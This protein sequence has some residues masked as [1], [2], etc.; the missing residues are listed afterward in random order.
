MKTIKT[1][2]LIIGA[3]PAGATAAA[4]LQ[5]E[6]V[7]TL[8]VEKLKFPRFVI[9]ESLLPRTMDL[10]KEMDFL[11][12]VEAC[13][14]IHKTGAVFRQGNQICDFDFEHQAGDGWKYTFHVPR[15][16][17][18][19]VIA[20]T[21]ASRGVDIRYEHEVKQVRFSEAQVEAEIKQ[22]DGATLHVV[23]Q[24]VLDCSGYGRVLPRL[25]D[26]EAPSHYPVRESLFTHVTG[27]LRPSGRDEGKIW[28]CMHPEGAWLWIIP[29]SNGRTSIGVVAE[30]EFYAR[31]PGDAETQLRAIVNSEPN[32]AKRLANM[33]IVFPPHRIKGFS[34]SIKQLFGP[35]YALA[36]NATEFLDPVFSS[37]VTLAM[38]SGLRAAQVVARQ[39]R[40]EAVDWPRDYADFIMQGVDTFRAYI[41]AWYDG[42]LPEILF[43]AQRNPDMMPKVCSVLAGYV[44]DK[45]NPF[46]AQ[47]DRALRALATVSAGMGAARN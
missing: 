31:Y 24:F 19:Q 34:I 40:G 21:V 39:L 38:E 22:P 29:F 11:A 7:R 37:G 17:F 36:G 32:G 26:L 28:V 30:P 9:G 6:G 3:G 47:A 23:A 44:W 14:F 8:V 5:R 13:G 2:V 20:D 46:V 18:D 25:L 33:Q 45:A 41:D 15:A 43:A 27:D 42:R 10:L 4:S 35:R 16:E 12:P 1:D